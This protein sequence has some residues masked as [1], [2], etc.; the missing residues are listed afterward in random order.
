MTKKSKIE[1]EK[2]F[3]LAGLVLFFMTL[4]VIY[5]YRDDIFQTIQDPRQPF[6][7]YTKPAA[8]DYRAPEMSLLLFRVSIVAG[9]IGCSVQMI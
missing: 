6:Q 1:I 3:L 9:N 7:T 8:P 4:I 5:L 2:P